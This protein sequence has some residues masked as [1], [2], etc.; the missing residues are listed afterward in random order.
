MKGRS[1]PILIF[2]VL[3]GYILLQFLWWEVLLV[4][5]NNQIISGKQELT[6]LSTADP[7]QL[8]QQIDSLLK[9]RNAR[10]LMIVGEGTVFL[11]I[12]LYGIF[13]IKKAHER[14]MLLTQRQK[15]FFLSITHELKTP[16][17]ATKL[18]LQTLKKQALDEAQQHELI[19]KALTET[20]RLNSLIDNILL[21]SRLEAGEY[22]FS[23][24][25]CRLKDVV[26]EV[27]QRYYPVLLQKNIVS[28]VVKHDP[29]VELDVQSFYSVITNLIDNAL[30]FSPPGSPVVAEVSQQGTSAV[31]R[32]A[33]K[34][35]GVRDADKKRIF[36]RFFRSGNEEIRNTRGTGLGLYITEY[37]VKK[38]NGRIAVKDNE[39][40]G[41]VFEVVL[42]AV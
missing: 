22:S 6:A 12:L 4:R 42:N 40:N 32:V 20:E 24:S 31:L 17:A 37:I 34:G 5:Q 8:R 33:D 21:A 2:T 27:I 19:G 28:L 3:V 23:F 26:G 10:T 11:L 29:A 36:E 18:Q 16:V 41:A 39:A 13:R 38:H 9:K 7:E 15:N 25:Q 30:K 14:E 35:P 1:R